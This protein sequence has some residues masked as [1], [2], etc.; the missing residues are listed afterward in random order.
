MLLDCKSSHET[1]IDVENK[2]I[3]VEN[4]RVIIRFGY[5]VSL[6]QQAFA[7]CSILEC[8]AQRSTC[9]IRT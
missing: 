9:D 4:K 6:K 5:K 8:P 3:D 2:S 1:I 7:Q